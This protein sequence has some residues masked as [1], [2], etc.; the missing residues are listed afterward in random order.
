MSVTSSSNPFSLH[1]ANNLVTVCSNRRY[2]INVKKYNQINLRNPK[3]ENE[4]LAI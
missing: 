2:Y 3:F 4:D 1:W